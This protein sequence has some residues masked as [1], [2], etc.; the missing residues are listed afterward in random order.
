MPVDGP[1]AAGAENPYAQLLD[2]APDAMLVVSVEGRILVANVQTEKL[3][4]YAREELLGKE[5]ELLI[6]DRFHL[7]HAAHLQRFAANPSTR[8]MGSGLEL[9]GRRRDGA[10]IAVE[11]SLSPVQWG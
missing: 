6:P 5:L 10:E 11:V 1:S 8:S 2:A 4:G 3:F 9:W 7:S